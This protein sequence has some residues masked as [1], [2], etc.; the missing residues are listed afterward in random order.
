[1]KTITIPLSG[2][3]A[4]MMAKLQTWKMMPPEI[5]VYFGGH[6]RKIYE[7]RNSKG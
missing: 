5:E 7:Q 6:F 2:V 1:M 4:V 3:E